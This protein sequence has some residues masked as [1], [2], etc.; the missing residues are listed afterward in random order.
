MCFQR[1]KSLPKALSSGIIFEGVQ[2]NEI[3]S[4]AEASG[5]DIVFRNEDGAATVEFCPHNA[6]D[7][8]GKTAELRAGN[9]SV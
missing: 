5:R 9:Q 3:D 4:G 2:T 1:S 7:L 6:N 8:C